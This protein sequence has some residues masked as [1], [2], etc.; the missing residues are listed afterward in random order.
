M[1]ACISN[2]IQICFLSE[3]LGVA[4]A[5]AGKIKLLAATSRI[6]ALP[7][8]PTF[9]DLGMPEVTDFWL[10]FHTPSGTPRPVVDK[11]NAAFLG[12][13]QTPEIRDF[14]LKGG[15]VISG[16]TPDAAAKRLADQVRTFV[17]IAKRVGLQPQ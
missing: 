11:L 13:I 10:A 6:P 15:F 16:T 2:E 12:T 5:S 3:L 9:A 4:Q 7:N 8:V 1:P 14:F 17:A